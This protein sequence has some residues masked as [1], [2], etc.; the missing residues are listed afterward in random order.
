MLVVRDHCARPPGPL[1]P[2]GGPVPAAAPPRWLHE[3]YRPRR[4]GALPPPRA[5]IKKRLGGNDAAEAFK[6]L[7]RIANAPQVRLLIYQF[8]SAPSI[9]I[10]SALTQGPY[11]IDLRST[12]Y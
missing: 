6:A 1:P 5:L 10:D 3:K 8:I 4:R 12:S 2:V 9:I 7:R 11:S